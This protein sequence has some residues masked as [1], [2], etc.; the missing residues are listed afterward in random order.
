[1]AL[2]FP[3][4]PSYRFYWKSIQLEPIP[5]SGERFTLG[6]IV[7][8]E[9]GELIVAKLI[10][11]TKLNSMFGGRIAARF[12][13]ALNL[14]TKSAESHYS[15]NNILEKWNSPIDGFYI[16]EAMKGVSKDIET[17]LELS[18]KNCSSLS[19]V[20]ADKKPKDL[21]K[22]KLDSA[23]WRKEIY[24][25]VTVNNKHYA[26]C[27]ERQVSVSK[28]GYPLTFGFVSDRYAAHFESISLKQSQQSFVKAQSK[29]WQLELLRER[30][31][32]DLF[33][34]Q[35]ERFELVLHKPETSQEENQIDD[36]IEELKE[37]ASMRELDL[38]AAP[39]VQSAAD[40]V[41]LLG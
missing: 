5:N 7:K 22:S 25:C 10:P 1:M 13:D 28:S 39:S 41:I 18:V 23:A 15:R 3:E 34:D 8:G 12:N 14:V 24:N 20:L 35:L 38:F 2:K 17:A 11:K 27:F 33:D 21:E 9:D 40:R 30:R 19:L 31:V 4:L 29:L 6:A 16:S 26:G 32:D 37:E 36:F